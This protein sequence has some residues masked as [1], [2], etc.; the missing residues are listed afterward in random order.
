M[1][2]FYSPWH[3]GSLNQSKVFYQNFKVKISD[4]K[5]RKCNSATCDCGTMK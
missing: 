2:H 3:P 5:K 4:E 1:L